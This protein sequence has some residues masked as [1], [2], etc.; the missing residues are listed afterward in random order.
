M[1]LHTNQKNQNSYNPKYTSNTKE[2][3][4]MT[5]NRQEIMISLK[6]LNDG[7]CSPSPPERG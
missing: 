2:S 1:V 3:F 7:Q 5:T 6:C 4:F